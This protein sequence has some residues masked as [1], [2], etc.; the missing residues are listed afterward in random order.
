MSLSA[1][2]RVDLSLILPAY[3]EAAIIV[4]NTDELERWMDQHMPGLNYEILVVNDGSTDNTAEALEEHLKVARHLR[5]SHHRFNM[6]R[7]RAIRTG[8][9]ESLGKYV[10]CLDA[11][12]SYV[13]EHIPDLL[14]PLQNGKADITLASAYH[15]QGSVRNVPWSRAILSKWGNMVLR[16]GLRGKYHTVTCVVRGYTREVLNLLEFSNNGKDLH[17]EVIQKAEMFGLRV[18]EVPGHLK[19]RDR[20]RGK[21]RK[22]RLLDYVPFLSMSGTI[23]SH[24]VYNYVLRPGSFL[25]IPVA[26]LLL[27]ATAGGALLLWEWISV[28]ISNGNVSFWGVYTALREVLF[29]GGLTLAISLSAFVIS[30][31]FIAFY[32]ASHQN[33][34]NFEEMYILLTR[35]N[36]RIKELERKS[37]S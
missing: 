15:P 27:L 8:F 22:T 21:K 9:D 2:S 5:V 3:N 11:D 26:A 28:V 20:D 33:K 12:L 13:P 16:S 23:A 25:N 36:A 4:R 37:D 6:G 35:M 24:L 18:V 17:L 31:I 34:R 32:F 19:W 1:E 7:G 29:R 30:L 10:I 14:R